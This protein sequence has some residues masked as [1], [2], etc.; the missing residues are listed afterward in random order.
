MIW[1]IKQVIWTCSTHTYIQTVSLNIHI[2][3][4]HSVAESDQF[5]DVSNKLLSQCTGASSVLCRGRFDEDLCWVWV[6]S[7]L[8]WL[9]W[10][11]DRLDLLYHQIFCKRE[12]YKRCSSI[13]HSFYCFNLHLTFTFYVFLDVIFIIWN[14]TILYTKEKSRDRKKKLVRL[15]SEPELSNIFGFNLETLK[16]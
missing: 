2:Y 7:F 6:A 11:I 9:E 5:V 14:W 8:L 1:C 3:I 12:L 15:L 10:P 4:G 16:C 13:I